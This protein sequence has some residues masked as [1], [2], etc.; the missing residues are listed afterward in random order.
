[1]PVKRFLPHS[2]ARRLRGRAETA[3]HEVLWGEPPACLIFSTYNILWFLFKIFIILVNDQKHEVLRSKAVRKL[4]HLLNFL[5]PPR[6]P[7]AVLS[8]WQEHGEAIRAGAQRAAR[9]SSPVG[10][11]SH[12]QLNLYI[13]KLAAAF[14]HGM[15]AQISCPFLRGNFICSYAS[16][17]KQQNG[18]PREQGRSLCASC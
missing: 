5:L 12:V 6:A 4:E 15:S 17:K 13:G 7:L 18:V 3:E 10:S 8:A 11:S 1:M 16:Q 14:S 2:R 9:H